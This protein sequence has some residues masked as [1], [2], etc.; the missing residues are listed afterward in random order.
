MAYHIKNKISK[1]EL[2]KQTKKIIPIKLMAFTKEAKSIL[3]AGNKLKKII[4]DY[5]KILDMVEDDQITR[6]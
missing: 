6:P 4:K 1:K 3:I 2:R 5:N